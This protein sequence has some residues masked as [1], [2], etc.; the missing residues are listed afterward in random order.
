MSQ[1]EALLN[2]LT[3][4]DHIVVGSDRRITVPAALKR[5]AVQY[6]HK[7]E[8]VTFDCPRYW[9]GIDMSTMT[10]YVNYKRSDGYLD[11][12]PV[13]NV[14]ID[15]VDDTIMH[16]DWTITRNVTM[17][18]GAIT[19]SIC[20]KDV[21]T[22]GNEVNHWNSELNNEMSVSEG[23][24][25]S[26]HIEEEYPDIIASLAKNK[27]DKIE[28]KGLSTNDF[29]N[30]EKAIMDYVI[31]ED[32]IDIGTI[33][34][35]KANMI[36]KIVFKG[37]PSG[38]I[39]AFNSISLDGNNL[40][41]NINT[42]VDLYGLD[43][44]Q[45]TIYI[46][47]DK[48]KYFK[49]IRQIKLGSDVNYSSWFQTSNDQNQPE[50]LFYLN[51]NDAIYANG[52]SLLTNE[53]LEMISKG[54]CCFYLG[55]GNAKLEGY[56]PQAGWYDTLE[57]KS[58]MVLFQQTNKNYLRLYIKDTELSDIRK[59]QAG[60]VPIAPEDMPEG[61][62]DIRTKE[63]TLYVATKLP[64]ITEESHPEFES[65]W[66]GDFIDKYNRDS[67]IMIN[68]EYRSNNID[69]DAEA[70]YGSILGFIDQKYNPQSTNPQSG[71]AVREA[72]DE[73]LGHAIGMIEDLLISKGLM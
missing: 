54:N 38:P 26:E 70:Q 15:D 41:F 33:N 72:I 53:E 32:T 34:L 9:D 8:T 69:F 48:I 56:N 2:S 24:E 11:A 14:R 4:E 21:D 45:D 61:S 30:E 52:E 67:Y 28:G 23:L 44:R 19:I 3:V 63:I 20:I 43:N 68:C 13:D 7:M 66:W 25:C 27:V 47:K 58:F 16:F 31:K 18:K 60:Y 73:A 12:V 22:D 65:A 55:V 59:V 49:N 1:A 42:K 17:V 10:I 64:V 5:I 29:T 40:P 57:D 46:Q 62:N 35:R 37:D 51:L 36:D 6:D 39:K 50:K 71:I